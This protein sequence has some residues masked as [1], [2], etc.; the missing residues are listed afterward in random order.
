VYIYHI[1]LIHSS[2][3]G[4][5]GYFHIFAIVNSAAVNIQVHISFSRKVLSG[6]MPKSGIAGLK[7]IFIEVWLIC[8]A[9]HI[10]AVQQNDS[11][12]Q[13]YFFH[14]LSIMVYHR[15]LNIVS[16]SIQ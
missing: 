8:N 7:F 2:V 16:C 5:L 1:F 12:I 6:Y 3:D 4:H 14:I 15:I 11:V 10:S 9:V 13:I